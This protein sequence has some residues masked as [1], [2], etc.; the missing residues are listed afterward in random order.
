MRLAEA[1]RMNRPFREVL[2]KKDER[3]AMK[4]Y[5]PKPVKRVMIL[6]DEMTSQ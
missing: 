3:G 2:Q 4:I 6:R 1:D 5:I